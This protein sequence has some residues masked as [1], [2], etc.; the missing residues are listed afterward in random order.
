[1]APWT[2]PRFSVELGEVDDFGQAHSEDTAVDRTQPRPHERDKASDDVHLREREVL[3]RHL[4]SMLLLI[5]VGRTLVGRTAVQ[6]LSHSPSFAHVRLEFDEHTQSV[7]VQDQGAERPT[8][9]QHDPTR[10]SPTALVV[11]SSERT[12]RCEIAVRRS[13]WFALFRSS[14]TRVSQVAV[15]RSAGGTAHVTRAQVPQAHV[16]MMVARRVPRETR[17]GPT[18]GSLADES[19]EADPEPPGRELERV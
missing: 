16:P 10:W 6:R 1:M 4:D 9:P 15:L 13:Q 12:H 2:T 11:A 7:I 8:T 14:L 17:A 19:D 18:R 3:S 5:S